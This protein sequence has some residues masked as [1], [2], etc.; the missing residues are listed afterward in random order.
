MM[1]ILAFYFA[2]PTKEGDV[3]RQTDEPFFRR[4]I[5]RLH[6]RDFLFGRLFS[7]FPNL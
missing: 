4:L 7:R 6:I 5:R 2:P 3:N 1:I